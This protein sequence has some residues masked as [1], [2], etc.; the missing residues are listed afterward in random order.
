MPPPSWPSAFGPLA[1]VNTSQ[2]VGLEGPSP[3]VAA[4]SPFSKRAPAASSPA[5]FDVLPQQIDGVRE[6]ISDLSR[7]FDDA[8]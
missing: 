8:G 7:H 4:G 1:L 2:G 3:V 5:M 6:G